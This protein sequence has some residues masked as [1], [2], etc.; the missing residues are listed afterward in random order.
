MINKLWIKFLLPTALLIIGSIFIAVVVIS[1]K[2]EENLQATA[3]KE[4]QQ[5]LEDFLSSLTITNNLMLEQVH[6][7][8]KTLKNQ[9]KGIGSPQIEGETSFLGSYI[10]NLMIGD[11]VIAENYEIVDRVKEIA[12][13]TATIFLKNGSEYL[14][15]STNVQKS[16][17]ERAIG[18]ILNPNGRAIKNIQNQ[19]AYYGLVNILEKPYLTGYEPIIDESGNTIGIWYTGYQLRSL[20]QL[21]E[22]LKKAR[23]LQ[24]G[25]VALIDEKGDPVFHSDNHTVEEISSIIENPDQEWK[26]TEKNF[27]EWGY[28]LVAALNINEIETSAEASIA[29]VIPVSYTHLTLPTTPYV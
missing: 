8:M 20:N 13:G 15:I 18:T 29:Q 12:G 21:G 17:G 23:I 2:V 7:G 4:I 27:E 9:A 26:L 24:E 14:R 11:H 19:E 28:K 16:N 25:F 5:N 22:A 3:E 6:I 1:S 10:P